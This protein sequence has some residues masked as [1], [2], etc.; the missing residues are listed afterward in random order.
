MSASQASLVTGK[1]DGH[2][3]NVNTTDVTFTSVG[4]WGV[5]AGVWVKF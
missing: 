3:V 1:Q 2:M 4:F 5:E